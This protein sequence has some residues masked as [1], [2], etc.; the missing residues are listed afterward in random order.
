MLRLLPDDSDADWTVHGVYEVGTGLYRIPLPLPSDALRAV[1]LYAV[2]DG[3]GLVMVDSGW[4]LAE[5]REL[6]E[7]AVKLL[8][9]SLAEVRRFLVTHVH[10]DHYTMA[11]SVRREFGTPI[12]LGRGEA[13]SLRLARQG[14]GHEGLLGQLRRGGGLHLFR[15]LRPASHPNASGFKAKRLRAGSV[16]GCAV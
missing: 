10:R 16:P 12:A 1:N 6:L 15:E 2:R 11:V 7:E 4:A 14:S 5:A 3:D 9:C 8:G 13:G